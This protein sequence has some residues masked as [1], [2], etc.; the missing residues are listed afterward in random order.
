[1]AV[2]IYTGMT[3]VTVYFQGI[4]SFTCGSN[5]IIQPKI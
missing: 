4:V 2:L 5:F 3:E 1:M